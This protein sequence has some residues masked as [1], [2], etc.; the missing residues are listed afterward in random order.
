MQNR[1][2]FASLLLTITSPQLISFLASILAILVSIDSLRVK[3][4][5]SGGPKKFI[6][7]LLNWKEDDTTDSE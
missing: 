4:K 2:A 1:L 5:K 7:N 3:V 6:N